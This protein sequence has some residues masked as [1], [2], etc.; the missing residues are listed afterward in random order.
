[1]I[2]NAPSINGDFAD[3]A[4]FFRVSVRTVAAWKDAGRLACFQQGRNVMF[5][6]EDVV[7]FKARYSVQEKGERQLAERQERARREWREHMALRTEWGD[8][9]ARLERLEGLVGDAGRA[10]GNGQAESAK[11]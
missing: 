8:L 6:A 4:A 2:L 5:G 9:H 3:V 7:A 10:E 1:M 11:Q